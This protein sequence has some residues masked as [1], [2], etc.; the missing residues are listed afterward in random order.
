M[1]SSAG[2]SMRPAKCQNDA[3]W[4][5]ERCDV[6]EFSRECGRAAALLLTRHISPLQNMP[7]GERF[8][9]HLDGA[10]VLRQVCEPVRRSQL[11]SVSPLLG[12]MTR[13]LTLHKGQGLAAPQLGV[14]LRLFMLAP[15]RRNG[16]PLVVLNPRVLRTSRAYG[17]DWEACLSVP[18]HGA[19]VERPQSVEVAF[20]T[21]SGTTVECVLRGDRARAFQHE[22][23]HLDGVLYTSRMFVSSY[24]PL[25]QL[26]S[27]AERAK[28]EALY[29]DWRGQEDRR[30]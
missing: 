10:S 24:A 1:P 11:A 21:L 16:R 12:E 7:V 30:V 14:S 22:C 28:F 6:A 25:S 17:V 23:D 18:G 3:N 26:D 4:R 5:E 19:L 8:R 9:L 27:E 15:E 13:M 2:C 20:D 29:L